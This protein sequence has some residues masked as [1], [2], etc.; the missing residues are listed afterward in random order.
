MTAVDVTIIDQLSSDGS[1]RELATR[2]TNALISLDRDH[3]SGGRTR[4]RVIAQAVPS[5]AA[6]GREA[7]WCVAGL[8]YV[9]WHA[10]LAGTRRWAPGGA[11]R[12][13]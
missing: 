1:K 10:H 8:D 11:G 6:P 12:T 7:D 9:A 2:L 4:W 3:R 5:A 13:A